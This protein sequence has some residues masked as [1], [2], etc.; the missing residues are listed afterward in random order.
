MRRLITVWT[1][2]T[3]SSFHLSV[4]GGRVTGTVTVCLL[5]GVK[6]YCVF[7][8]SVARDWESRVITWLVNMWCCMLGEPVPLGLC[9]DELP[10]LGGLFRSS[11]GVGSLDVKSLGLS[12]VSR[13]IVDVAGSVLGGTDI[14]VV[15]NHLQ[16]RLKRY[17]KDP[18]LLGCPQLLQVRSILEN[19]LM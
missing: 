7:S 18:L 3:Y 16:K 9:C 14:H 11:T 8:F 19:W 1:D 15:L 5:D 4:V 13:A 12:D 17:V 2:S 10:Q 6:H